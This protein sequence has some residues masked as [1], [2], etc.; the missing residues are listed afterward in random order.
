MRQGQRVEV[1]L[2]RGMADM[3][4]V[5]TVL[6]PARME[7]ELDAEQPALPKIVNESDITDWRLPSWLPRT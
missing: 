2:N 7:V 3:W 4:V 5:A 6:D 1:L